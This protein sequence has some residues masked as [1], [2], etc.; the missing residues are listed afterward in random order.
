MIKVLLADDHALFRRGLRSMLALED[1]ILIV[2]EAADGQEAQELAAELQPDIVLLDINMPRVTGIQAAQELRRAHPNLG[3][4]MLTMFAED[5]IVEEAL[6]AGADGYLRKDTPFDDLVATVRATAE[7]RAALPPQDGVAIDLPSALT[8]ADLL[9]RVVDGLTDQEIA[10][11]SGLSESAVR[12]RLAAL[13]RRIG[14]A[15]R[16]QAAIYALTRGFDSLT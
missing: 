14:A 1:D 12:D 10:A 3:I 16:T 5:E 7:R 6:A 9:R 15:D 11:V 8:D 4:V 13:Y 2:G